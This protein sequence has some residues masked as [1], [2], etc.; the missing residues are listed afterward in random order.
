MERDI[1]VWNSK[2]Y[3][4]KPIILKEDRLIKEHRKYLQ[5]INYNQ[6]LSRYLLPVAGG[7]SSSTLRAVSDLSNNIP[8]NGEGIEERREI[9]YLMK[10]FQFSPK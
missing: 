1:R 2:T 5:S 6:F 10:Y 7:T 3:I 9:K 4:D 8:W